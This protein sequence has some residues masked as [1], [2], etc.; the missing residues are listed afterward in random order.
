MHAL[1]LALGSNLGARKD[2]LSGACAALERCGIPLLR[3]SHLFETAPVGGP[4]GQPPYLNAALAAETVLTPL[5]LLGTCQRIEA[6]FGRE[7]RERWG[8][9]TLDIDILAYDELLAETAR[10]T[11]PHPRLHERAFVLAPLLE[12]APDWRHPRL[13]KTTRQ[14]WEELPERSTPGAWRLLTEEW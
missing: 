3:R 10:L 12:V 11:L 6:L 8:A 14:L 5:E 4:T 1:L 2:I 7:R 9:R 13:G